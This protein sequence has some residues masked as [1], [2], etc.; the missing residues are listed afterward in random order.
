MSVMSNLVIYAILTLLLHKVIGW[1]WTIVVL[2]ATG[3][4][5]GIVEAYADTL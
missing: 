1:G 4:A 3:A 2:M 5:L